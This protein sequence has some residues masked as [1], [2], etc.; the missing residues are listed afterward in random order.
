M[1]VLL[2]EQ[3]IILPINIILIGRIIKSFWT[4][5]SSLLRPLQLLCNAYRLL[6]LCIETV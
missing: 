1:I 6:L 2:P 3:T 5:K 4:V